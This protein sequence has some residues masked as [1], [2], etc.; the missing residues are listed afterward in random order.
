[1]TDYTTGANVK[2]NLGYFSMPDTDVNGVC[3]TIFAAHYL[4][5]SSNTCINEVALKDECKSTL[6]PRDWANNLLVFAGSSSNSAKIPVIV[7]SLYYY[8]DQSGVYTVGDPN[9][10]PASA[11]SD[12]TTCS[13]AN[14]LKEIQYTVI[15]AKKNGADFNL[16]EDFNFL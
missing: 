12:G 15:T 6:N 7:K 14:V 8:D 16:Q 9:A 11:I 1:M 10:V 4:E 13:C 3:N 5:G 2:P